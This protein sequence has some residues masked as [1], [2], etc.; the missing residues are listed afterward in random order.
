MAAI[1]VPRAL[2]GVG[3]ALFAVGAVLMAIGTTSIG[4]FVFYAVLTFGGVSVF[5][6]GKK[7]QER[8]L[9]QTR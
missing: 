7:L 9:R 1:T 5:L 2:Q 6:G 8:S 4:L 3:L